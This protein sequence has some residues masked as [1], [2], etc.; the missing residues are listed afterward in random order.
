MLLVAEAVER[1]HAAHPE[2]DTDRYAWGL[3]RLQTAC[4]LVGRGVGYRE[5]ARELQRRR[6]DFRE[7]ALES[8]PPSRSR[9][10]FWAAYL[11]AIVAVCIWGSTRRSRSLRQGPNQSLSDR[12]PHRDPDPVRVRAL[13]RVHGTDANGRAVDPA[14]SLS[15]RDTPQS[16]RGCR[17]RHVCV[18]HEY[19]RRAWIRRLLSSSGRAHLLARNHH[20]GRGTPILPGAAGRSVSWRSCTRGIRLHRLWRIH[21][22]PR[23]RGQRADAIRVWRSKRSARRN[24]RRYRSACRA[25]PDAVHSFF[26]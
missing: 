11:I 7:K 3:L 8:D 22:P 18:H 1:V 15:R 16:V 20:R 14:L 12:R 23:N 10:F 17:I 13:F 5:V 19:P 2:Y 6:R 9:I 25:R 4:E 26:G 24:G 21:V